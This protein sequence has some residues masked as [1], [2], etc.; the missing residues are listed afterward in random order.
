MVQ[1][2]DRMKKVPETTEEPIC[3]LVSKDGV[4]DDLQVTIVLKI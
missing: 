4:K 1:I 2:Q 3:V